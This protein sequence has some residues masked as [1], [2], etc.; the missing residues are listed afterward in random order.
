MAWGNFVSAAKASAPAVYGE[1]KYFF[2]SSLFFILL[3]C[4][5][6]FA[7]SRLMENTHPS[8]VFLLAILGISIV[9]YGT[10]TQGVGSAELKDVP[11]KVAVAGG[12]GVLAAVFGF[13]IVW[14]SDK[15]Q[16]VFKTEQQYGLIVLENKTDQLFDLTN[17]HIAAN[18]SDGR[19]LYLLA[20]ANA[21]EVLMPI[22]S[23]STKSSV[24]ITITNTTG[25]SMTGPQPC[26]SLQW[27]TV[28]DNSYGEQIKHVA[29]AV[30][31]L[32]A[33]KTSQVDEANRAVEQFNFVAK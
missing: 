20:K 25:K 29:T 13:G 6:L 21:I 17:L 30:L 23:F 14:Q 2:G 5:F 18:S 22:S 8:F 31:P 28:T 10:G 16:R 33:P 9:L 4:S 3:G 1:I 26:P 7:A 19:G 12:A 15:I 32:V 27:Q 11:I 24:C